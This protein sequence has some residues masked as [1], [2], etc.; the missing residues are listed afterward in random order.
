MGDVFKHE[1]ILVYHLVHYPDDKGLKL[2]SVL[3][4]SPHGLQYKNST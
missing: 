2:E 1:S 3:E 4:L